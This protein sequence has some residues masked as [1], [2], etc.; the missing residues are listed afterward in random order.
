[1]Y[2]ISYFI[3]AVITAPDLIPILIRNAQQT[4]TNT[5]KENEIINSKLVICDDDDHNCQ[6]IESFRI[7]ENNTFNCF[8]K[9]IQILFSLEK[10]EVSGF[11]TDDLSHILKHKSSLRSV[12][13]KLKRYIIVNKLILKII[14]IL[15]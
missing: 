15:F 13:K 7:A 4:V 3:A 2:T 11:L 8:Q 14:F 12:C 6:A 1:L 5:K 9:D 10:I